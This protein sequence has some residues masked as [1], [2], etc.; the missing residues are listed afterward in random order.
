V[1]RV[2]LTR[3]F[4]ERPQ[5]R[6]KAYTHAAASVNTVYLTALSRSLSERLK[7]PAEVKMVKK[8]NLKLCRQILELDKGSFPSYLVSSEQQVF[9]ISAERD[10][11]AVL[12]T[13]KKTGALIGYL[14]AH[15]PLSQ[16]HAYYIESIAVKNS[17]RNK[18]I[19]RDM[20]S[21]ITETAKQMDYSALTLLCEP[22]DI[23][24]VSLVSF[25][26]SNGFFISDMAQ[27]DYI[28]RKNI[29]QGA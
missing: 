27:S 3:Y 9:N 1:R 21:I 12:I 24:G 4:N 28:M 26:E 17:F 18:H 10:F 25:Y 23:H 8:M 29:P 19:A 6:A 15:A 11:R 14:L 13:N 22:Q 7:I 2:N 16:D 20:V 5:V